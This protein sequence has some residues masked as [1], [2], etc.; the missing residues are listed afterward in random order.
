LARKMARQWSSRQQLPES[1]GN[2]VQ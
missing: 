1:A 2:Q